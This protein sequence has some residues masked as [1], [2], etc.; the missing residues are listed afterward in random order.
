M[1]TPEQKKGTT[2][3]STTRGADLGVN[4]THNS[5][6]G[7]SN[8]DDDTNGVPGTTIAVIVMAAIAVLGLVI[9][10]ALW[11]QKQSKNTAVQEGRNVVYAPPLAT[12]PVYAG[13]LQLASNP[14]YAAP[15]DDPKG[16]MVRN[17]NT[18][19]NNF[20]QFGQRGASS[21]ASSTI[22]AVYAIPL[23]LAGSAVANN[24]KT[25][26]SPRATSTAAT[27]GYATPIA[28]YAIPSTVLPSPVL[29][30]AGYV[31]DIGGSH[32]KNAGDNAT[33]A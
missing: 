15:N 1:S 8:T 24:K 14:S 2:I 20:K 4:Q 10:I 29:D 18:L 6:I 23:A 5:S 33:T 9:G 21:G 19:D 25:S 11:F 30:E 16:Q 28:K 13:P 32:S 22:A 27:S 3:H 12:N 26:G 31:A 7:N 17:R